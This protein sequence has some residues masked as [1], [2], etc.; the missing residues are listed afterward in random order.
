M[1]YRN[2]PIL[3]VNLKFDGLAGSQNVSALTPSAFMIVITYGG[4]LPPPVCCHPETTPGRSFSVASIQ[5]SNEPPGSHAS[6]ANAGSAVSASTHE[7]QF[8]NLAPVAM[9]MMV[10]SFWDV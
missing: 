8:T 10:L 9:S 5:A 7:R 3:L 1:V 4:A 6:P 2:S